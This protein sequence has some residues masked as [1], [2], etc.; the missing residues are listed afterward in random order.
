MKKKGSVFFKILIVLLL[1]CFVIL[2]VIPMIAKY[3]GFYDKPDGGGLTDDRPWIEN[4]TD[5]SRVICSEIPEDVSNRGIILRGVLDESDIHRD[6]YYR[7][8]LNGTYCWID[9]YA[10]DC[11]LIVDSSDEE[12]MDYCNS[13]SGFDDPFFAEASG[14]SYFTCFFRVAYKP[15]NVAE[16]REFEIQFFRSGLYARD[17]SEGEVMVDGYTGVKAPVFYDPSGKFIMMLNPSYRGNAMDDFM[18]AFL[19]PKMVKLE[20]ST[21]NASGYLTEDSEEIRK[22]VDC[23]HQLE[24]SKVEEEMQELAMAE[25]QTYF[26]FTDVNG[27]VNDYVI[28]GEYLVSKDIIYHIDNRNALDDLM[29]IAESPKTLPSREFFENLDKD[30]SLD[31]IVD[32]IGGY[33]LEGSGIIY[34]VWILDDGSKAELVFNSSGQIEFIYIVADDHSERIYDR[35]NT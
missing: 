2:V 9:D 20:I 24:L 16:E 13:F 19:E 31:E 29:A 5:D 30:S 32:Q 3:A 33:G 17:V 34:H 23:M 10:C 11:N 8:S 18:L 12:F 25:N 14:N 22:A 26:S 7:Y 21:L 28:V 27:Y 35:E 1:L 6:Y 4:I 15:V